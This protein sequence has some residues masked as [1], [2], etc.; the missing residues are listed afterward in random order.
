M[1]HFTRLIKVFTLSLLGLI[2]TTSPR[3]ETELKTQLVL[4]PF[5]YLLGELNNHYTSNE[6][7]AAQIQKGSFT[8]LGFQGLWVKSGIG[9]NMWCEPNWLKCWQGEGQEYINP[10]GYISFNAHFASDIWQIHAYTTYHYGRYY[11]STSLWHYENWMPPRHAISLGATTQYLKINQKLHF[12]AHILWPDQKPILGRQDQWRLD[13]KGISPLALISNNTAIL[14]G[15]YYKRIQ[16]HNALKDYWGINAEIILS[17]SGRSLF[18]KY[19]YDDYDHSR[20][21]F[22]FAVG[23][24]P[25][26]S[27]SPQN[28]M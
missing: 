26:T 27:L 9:L 8:H 7:I 18:L 28:F 25:I 10:M 5:Q 12:N 3:C 22:G 17:F 1:A 24:R 14:I 21:N 23:A 20:I 11:I 15:P 19:N 6:L 13:I 16:D 2:F 4:I